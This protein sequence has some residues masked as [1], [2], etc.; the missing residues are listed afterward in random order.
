MILN[1][2]EMQMARELAREIVR[3][4]K[5]KERLERMRRQKAF[6]ESVELLG[7]AIRNAHDSI[8]EGFAKPIANMVKSIERGLIV[9]RS[10]DP[11][12]R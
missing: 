10:S 3:V 6:E 7:R 4:E 2:R 9:E 8:I 11:L 5:E 1:K 12:S